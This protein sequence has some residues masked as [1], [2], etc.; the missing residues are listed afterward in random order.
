MHARH[1]HHFFLSPFFFFLLVA[2]MMIDEARR[3]FLTLLFVA[4]KLLYMVWFS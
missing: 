2:R 1:G 4:F 3:A